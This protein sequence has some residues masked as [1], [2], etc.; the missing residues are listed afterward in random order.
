MNV[1]EEFAD[2]AACGMVKQMRQKAAWHR[3]GNGLSMAEYKAGS[4]A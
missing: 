1:C 3:A 4:M 2:C